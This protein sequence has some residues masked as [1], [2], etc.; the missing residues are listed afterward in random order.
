MT[1]KVDVRRQ[2]VNKAVQM[3]ILF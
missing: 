3:Y 1:T 2:M